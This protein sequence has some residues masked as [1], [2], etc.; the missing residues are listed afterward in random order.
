MKTD[1]SLSVPRGFAAIALDRPKFESNVGGAMRAA[2]CFGASTIFLNAKRELIPIIKKFKNISADVCKA[3]RHIPTVRVDNILESIPFGAVPIAVEID[4]KAKSIHN[5]YHPER[6]LYIFGP[7]DGNI[8]KEI[9]D[10]C[11][12]KIFIPSKFCLNLA[13]AV[14]VVLFHRNMQM[15]SRE[16]KEDKPGFI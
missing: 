13:C 2:A 15:E 5:F 8:S 3:W 7:E 12:Y 9:M 6:G 10:K 11:S 16:F 1:N 4:D 14:N